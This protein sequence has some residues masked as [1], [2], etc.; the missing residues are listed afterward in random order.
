MNTSAF[1]TEKLIRLA[2]EYRLISDYRMT[3]WEIELSIDEMTLSFD[4]E[5]ARFYLRG[6]I[7]GYHERT[8]RPPLV[9]PAT[10]RAAA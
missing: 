8:T 5:E 3:P 9:V 1:S 7:Q 10:T 2:F 6:L 4:P